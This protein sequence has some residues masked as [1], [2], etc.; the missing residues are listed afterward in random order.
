MPQT[1]SEEKRHAAKGQEVVNILYIDQ[2]TLKEV[3][4]RQE[5]ATIAWID[6]KN[7]DDWSCKLRIIEY[8]K[9]YKISDKVIIIKAIENWKVELA[10]KG[11]TL[12]EVKIEIT[13]AIVISNCNDSSQ[14]GG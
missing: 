9:M 6:Y 1:I 11:Q 8:L 4:T 2:Y 12:E 13:L 5:N 10:A 14:F 7:A 3:K